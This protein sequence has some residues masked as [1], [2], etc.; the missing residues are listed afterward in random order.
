MLAAPSPLWAVAIAVLSLLAPAPVAAV[1]PINPSLCHCYLTNGPTA[2]YFANHKFFDFRNIANPRT[3][4]PI[5]DRAGATNA[6]ITHAYFNST[7]FTS[8]WSVQAWVGGQSDSTVYNTYSKNDVF[9]SA[10]TDSNPS[11]RTYL[12]LRTYRHP[13]GNFQSS[14]E[15]QS[16]SASYQYVSMRMYARTRGASGAVA[17][18][19]TYRGGA[20]DADVQEADLEILT[21]DPTNQI[22]Y[23][24]QPSTANGESRPNATNQVTI[25]GAWTSWRTHRYDWTPS[26]SDWYV[27]GTRVN[28]NSYQVPRDPA[29]LLFN[30]WSDGGSW[31]GVMASGQQAEMDIQWIEIIYNNTGEPSRFA[32]CA[33]VCSLDLSSQPGVPVL[34]SSGP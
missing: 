9:I 21:R 3:P 22:H 23:T 25:S 34:V 8:T 20:T 1:S 16:I 17:A 31:S 13:A 28:S 32:H 10:N 29:T 27:D 24:N 2:R 15:V 11:S 5:N 18:M 19:F 33:N 30:T 6:P 12:S 7:N 26:S 14:A 4:P